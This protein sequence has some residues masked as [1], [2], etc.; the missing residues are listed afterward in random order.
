M[1]KKGKLR[2][3]EW[4]VAFLHASHRDLVDP[5]QL[6]L[7]AM[8]PIRERI[9]RSIETAQK[10]STADPS[11]GDQIVCDLL[12]ECEPQIP[13]FDLFHGSDSHYRTELFDDVARAGNQILVAYDT[14]TDN[15]AVFVNLGQ[16]LVPLVTGPELL[17]Q[18]NKNILAVSNNQKAKVFSPLYKLLKQ[19]QEDSASTS[20][21]RFS[22]VCRA[23]L[24]HLPKL[25][26]QTGPQSEAAG[27]VRG[28]PVRWSYAALLCRLPKRIILN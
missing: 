24:P 22:K 17:A 25:L 10:A 27:D 19:I 28:M 5:E 4:H 6:A 14:T 26:T 23:V 13:L 21:E 1:A 9:L 20:H 7:V 3:S 8:K 12:D 16:R 15:A 11:A 2:W 18:I